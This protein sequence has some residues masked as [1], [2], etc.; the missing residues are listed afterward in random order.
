MNNVRPVSQYG[1]GRNLVFQNTGA[2]V[3]KGA[4]L[5]TDFGRFI[6]NVHDIDEYRNRLSG[7]RILNLGSAHNGYVEQNLRALAPDAHYVSLDPTTSFGRYGAQVKGIAQKLPFT[8]EA[9]HTVISTWSLPLL[10]VEALHGQHVVKGKP[11]PDNLILKDLQ[12]AASEVSRVL[13]PGGEAWLSPLGIPIVY[14]SHLST[15]INPQLGSST[16]EK[17]VV[18]TFEEAGLNL[19]ETRYCHVEHQ[20]SSFSYQAGIFKK[21]A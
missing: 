12:Q 18:S 3:A 2:G 9:F 4:S 6:W 14:D 8:K 21:V 5:F 17:L 7:G 20:G 15:E 16:I 13:V 1:D 10:W 11:L 19:A